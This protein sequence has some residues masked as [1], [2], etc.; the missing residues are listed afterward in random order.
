[1]KINKDAL[2]CKGW[3]MSCPSL[4]PFLPSFL[5]HVFSLPLFAYLLQPPPFSIYSREL[6]LPTITPF[7]I[8]CWLTLALQEQGSVVV[9]L[10]LGL[11]HH[12][13]GVFLQAQGRHAYDLMP[14]VSTCPPGKEA[15]PSPSL[16]PFPFPSPSPSPHP[17]L[18]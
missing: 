4:P 2:V 3:G 5:S 18:P 6:S 14:N 9:A 11:L 17:P 7:L 1:M 16:L 10:G 15:C 12:D 13:A 8:S